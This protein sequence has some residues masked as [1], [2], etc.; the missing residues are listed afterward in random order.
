M[1]NQK[2]IIQITQAETTLHNWS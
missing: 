1:E 2:G